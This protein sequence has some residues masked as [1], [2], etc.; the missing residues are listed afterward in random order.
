MSGAE[1][2]ECLEVEGGEDGG[3]GGIFDSGSLRVVGGGG[4]PRYVL[5]YFVVSS[6]IDKMS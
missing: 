6:P 1:G 2:L 3:R 4:S 5:T